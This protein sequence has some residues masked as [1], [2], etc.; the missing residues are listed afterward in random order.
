M[1]KGRGMDKNS[2]GTQAPCK[3]ADSVVETDNSQKLDAACEAYP[4]R[5]RVDG[6]GKYEKSSTLRFLDGWAET[7]PAVV[8]ASSGF[9]PLPF[10]TSSQ[11]L[12]CSRFLVSLPAI[13]RPPELE[14]K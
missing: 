7:F 14:M 11:N 5:W 3:V 6:E 10:P 8:D 9:R 13:G 4:Q 1:A 12:L 2:S